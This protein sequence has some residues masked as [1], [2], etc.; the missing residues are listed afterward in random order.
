MLQIACISPAKSNVSET[1]NTLRYAARAKKIRTKPI[2]VMDPREALILSLKREVNALQSENDHL[3]SAI[4]FAQDKAPG[5]AGSD[6]GNQ[7]MQSRLFLKTPPSVDMEKLAEMEGTEL[8]ELVRHYM[9]EN[10]ALRKE[11]AELFTTRE[12]VL[13]DQELQDI[14][15]GR[16][17]AKGNHQL[18]EAIQKELDK[19]SIGNSMMNI[20]ESYREKSHRRHNSWDNSKAS[21]GSTGSADSASSTR[22]NK[23]DNPNEDGLTGEENVQVRKM[24]AAQV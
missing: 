20:G 4:H 13:R 12:L 11:N 3:R 18:P 2:V 22:K 17:S 9:T 15:E 19:R 6:S 16:K 23:I 10:E 21:R 8:T 7:F 5:T 14:M 24:V 1:M